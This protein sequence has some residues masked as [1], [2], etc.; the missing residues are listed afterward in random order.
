VDAGTHDDVPPPRTPA[1]TSHGEHRAPPL[2][3]VTRSTPVRRCRTVRLRSLVSPSGRSASD[4][5]PVLALPPSG[6]RSLRRTDRPRTQADTG[7]GCP[8]AL[9]YR[10]DEPASASPSFLYTSPQ[11]PI[12]DQSTLKKV[13]TM[14]KAMRKGRAAG[15]AAHLPCDMFRHPQAVPL[16]CIRG[17]EGG[18]TEGREPS[19]H[20]DTKCL[21][22]APFPPTA[23]SSGAYPLT[24]DFLSCG[25][26]APR[27]GRGIMCHGIGGQGAWQ[28]SLRSG[29]LRR[30]AR[31]EWDNSRRRTPCPH[32][33]MLNRRGRGSLL[34]VHAYSICVQLLGW[35]GNLPTSQQTLSVF[36]FGRRSDCT[37]SFLRRSSRQSP[38]PAGA[39]VFAL[40]PQGLEPS[41]FQ[42]LVIPPY[43]PP[44][45]IYC[46]W[47]GCPLL[48]VDSCAVHV[49]TDTGARKEQGVLSC[50]H[51]R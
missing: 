14:Q 3:R 27:S 36:E 30:P 37:A 31:A 15:R 4:V 29:R 32:C 41:S 34:V 45:G 48:L 1:S 22:T 26:V 11:T 46:H 20:V 13:N 12:I 21:L 28:P 16:S 44:P 9:V 7:N 33:L 43:R 5:P 35:S 42:H 40:F 17:S 6:T 18:G 19:L 2:S 49:S 47:Y 50:G 8:A 51:G 23:P 38:A 25:A 24:P 39:Q 10:K